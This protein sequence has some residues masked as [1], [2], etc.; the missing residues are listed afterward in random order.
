MMALMAQDSPYNLRFEID[1]SKS[2][3]M[4]NGDNS[5]TLAKPRWVC[6]C[7]NCAIMCLS[8]LDY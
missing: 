4:K 5:V 2:Q 6:E 1:R 8:T 7:A 3:E